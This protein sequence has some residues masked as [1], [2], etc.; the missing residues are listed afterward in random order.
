MKLGA[1]LKKLPNEAA[2]TAA[3]A[4][5]PAPPPSEDR[6][7]GLVVA[8]STDAQELV[9][10]FQRPQVEPVREVE[11]IPQPTTS[12]KRRVP[13]S[14]GTCEKCGAAIELV[15]AAE[16]VIELDPGVVLVVPFTELG[17]PFSISDDVPKVIGH[18]RD[19]VLVGGWK[20]PAGLHTEKRRIPVQRPHVQ[21]C[22]VGLWTTAE[23]PRVAEVDVETGPVQE[24]MRG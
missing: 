13:R 24:V 17:G 6:G 1:L 8:P 18:Y 14:T 3:P 4:P 15:H 10:S 19:D 2:P 22:T 21:S 20:M 12:G 11:P 7:G 23:P 9:Q 5:P 16:R